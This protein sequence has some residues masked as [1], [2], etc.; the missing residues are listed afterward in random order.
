MKNKLLKKKQQKKNATPTNTKK[1]NKWVIKFTPPGGK[2]ISSNPGGNAADRLHFTQ[3]AH[4][5]HINGA[6]ILDLDK[7]EKFSKKISTMSGGTVAQRNELNKILLQRRAKQRE[8]QTI[9]NELQ[10]LKETILKG[11]PGSMVESYDLEIFK[12]QLNKYKSI[13]SNALKQNLKYFLSKI[14]P[15]ADKYNIKLAICLIF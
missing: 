2:H 5:P 7:K 9:E 10:V 1:Q 3:R 6:N 4:V 13:D 11:L 12:T 8:L 14:G 15:T